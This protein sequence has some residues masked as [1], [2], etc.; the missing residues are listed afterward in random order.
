[1]DLLRRLVLEGLVTEAEVSAVVARRAALAEPVPVVLAVLGI[2]STD[3]VASILDRMGYKR[4]MQLRPAPF[5]HRLPKGML[6]AFWALPIGEGPAGVVVAMVDPTDQHALRELEYHLGKPVDPRVASA[7]ALQHVLQEVD[8]PLA[9]ERIPTRPAAVPPPP[10]IPVGLARESSDSD[11]PIVPLV[12][13]AAHQ[14]R[15][16]WTLSYGQPRL[17]IVGHGIPSA[18]VMA[19]RH[20]RD[21]RVAQAPGSAVRASSQYDNGQSRESAAP[22]PLRR[23]P[24]KQRIPLPPPVPPEAL[25]ALTELRTVHDRDAIA[26]VAVRG[27]LAVAERAAFFVI[28]GGVVQ[29]WEGAT[30]S[31]IGAAGLAREALRNLWIPLTAASVFRRVLDQGE[32]Y[33]GPLSASTPDSTLAAALGGR[34]ERVLIAPVMV[35]KRGV[36]FLYA[37]GFRDPAEAETRAQ[38]IATATAEALE[39]WLVTRRQTR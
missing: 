33:C 6:R 36:A 17:T 21:V 38:T 30:L 28:K 1:M 11:G 20:I 31:E 25:R 23:Q 27:L 29:G 18:G 9:A 12:S 35:R 2:A 39:R 3:A 13:Q 22:I 4:A 37:D 26:R 15:R 8:P 34:P 24:A 10:S 19:D 16:R 5:V 14:R 32:I 7:D